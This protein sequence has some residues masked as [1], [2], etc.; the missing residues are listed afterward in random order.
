MIAIIIII[1]GII[2]SANVHSTLRTPLLISHYI[3]VIN[4]LSTEDMLTDIKYLRKDKNISL[5]ELTLLS[6]S[7]RSRAVLSEITP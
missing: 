4:T 3:V 5:T 2:R 1:T 6:T 7:A